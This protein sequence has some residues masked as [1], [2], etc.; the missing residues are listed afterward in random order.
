MPKTIE[1]YLIET[2]I[3]NSKARTRQL[4]DM[5]A[6][7]EDIIKQRKQTDILEMGNYTVHDK[8]GK[9]SNVFYQVCS[10][11]DEAGDDYWI[12][13]TEYGEVIYSPDENTI[14]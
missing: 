5:N 4:Q 8:Y 9:I 2:A 6:S 1:Q 10:R 12:F 7:C 14:L 11:I 13:K 3:L